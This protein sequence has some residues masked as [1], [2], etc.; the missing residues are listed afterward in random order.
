MKTLGLALTPDFYSSIVRN[1]SD[2]TTVIN[3]QGIYQ[4]LSDSV[5]P[6]LGYQ[7][8]QLLG[9]HILELIH[10][11]DLEM[12]KAEMRQMSS[13]NTRQVS[14]PPFRYMAKNGDWHWLSCV[15]TN[16]LD[17]PHVQGIVTNS[18]DITSKMEAVQQKKES[19]AYYKALFFNNPDP[20]IT[21]STTGK[22]LAINEAMVQATGYSR[23]ERPNT[24][25]TEYVVPENR[26]DALNAF[27]E[28]L[29]GTPSTFEASILDSTGK[30][31]LLKITLVPVKLD[32]LVHA[33][34]CIAKDITDERD[35][36]L[37]V[38]AH[39]QKQSD[40]LESMMEGFFALDT[41]WNYIFGNT[42]FARF[43]NREPDS[44][45]NR[46]IWEEYPCL[47]QSLFYTKCQQVAASGQSIQFNEYF[48]EIA[49]TLRLSVTCFKNGLLVSFVD[50]S[51]QVAAQDRL[52]KLSLVASHTTNGV[53]ITNKTGEIEWVNEAFE[54]VTGYSSAEVAGKLPSQIL[55]DSS[56]EPREIQW[57]RTQL[58]QG[59]P[60][61]K[62]L[63]GYRK[64]GDLIW[65][66]ITISPIK[67]HEGEVINHVYIH[68]DITERKLDQEHL[69]KA[70]EHLYLQNQDLQ[71]FNYIVSHN[72]RAPVANLIGLSA[73]L[74]KVDR[75]G[76]RMEQG[77]RH[78]EDSARRLDDVISDL[79]KILAVRTANNTESYEWVVLP[80]VANAVIQSMQHL[81]DLAQGSV[82]LVMH[83]KDRLWANRAYVYSILHNLISN[84][85]KYKSEQRSLDIVLTTVKNE[86]GLTLTVTDNGSG[87]NMEAVRPRLFQL[88]K[89]FHTGH[90]GKGIGLYLVKMQV[91]A[92]GGDIDVNSS[93]EVGTT[94]TITFDKIAYDSQNNRN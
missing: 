46:C 13:T 93:P 79:N 33:V 59:I 88:Y 82:T 6:I 18:R 66:D 38:Q 75:S 72:L 16:M 90:E 53:F 60:V 11:E 45:M 23:D 68:T 44:L 70:T 19:Q 87:M 48:P 55:A 12:V 3:W 71:Q 10:P 42:V 76:S 41:N 32:G 73:T 85:I 50:I 57:I 80:E 25:F 51:E 30:K 21:L 40:I 62:E 47:R 56:I 29:Q 31:R 14:L 26:V 28:T 94:F 74:Q 78:L 35:A 92:M 89:R 69:L 54:Q 34:Q 77:L 1:G 39:V 24:H 22:V 17:N 9:C 58:A 91:N 83:E 2:L 63:R 4:Y 81:L 86:N 37:L 49:A 7:P 5:T 20:I 61:R 52:R 36:Q 64:N 65:A 67:N 27:A 43:L 84:A 15:A 8:G